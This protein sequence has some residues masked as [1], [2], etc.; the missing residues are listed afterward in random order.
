MN[1]VTK[2][3]IPLKA[4]EDFS[5]FKLFLADI[6]LLSAMADLGAKTLLEGS[7][8]FSEFKGALTEQY[9]FQQM[10]CAKEA[11]IYYWSPDNVRSEIDFIVRFA[12]Q[13]IP[14][15]V[16]AEENLRAKSLR[17]Y[18]SKYHPVMA[19]RTSMSDFRKE[20]WMTNMPLYAI[21]ELL[22]LIEKK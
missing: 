22:N 2:P 1:N 12:G 8:V 13:V 14:V 5:A 15:G 3:A 17:V 7:A 6:G 16:K 18:Q 21:G 20:E 4:Y 10:M 9:V 19:I 11:V